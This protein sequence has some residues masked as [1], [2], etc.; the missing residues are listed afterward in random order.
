[1]FLSSLRRYKEQ[2][3]GAAAAGDLGDTSDPRRVVVTEFRVI[4]EDAAKEDLTFNIESEA[5]LK[6]LADN[7]FV[8]KEKSKYKFSISFKVQH[9]IVAGLKFT[10]N[11]KKAVFSDN[12]EIVIGS[13]APQ[14]EPHTFTFPR[15][16]WNETPSGMMYRGGYKGR[17]TFTDSDNTKHSE[18]VY[19]FTVR[20]AAIAGWG[21]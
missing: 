7:A 5:G 16:G 4:F 21:K 14:S 9:E 8:M 10:N 1:M 15:H 20:H 17:G 19:K 13:Y 2:L 6:S 3:L 18:F 11:V 12:E